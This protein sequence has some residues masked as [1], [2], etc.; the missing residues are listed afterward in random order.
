MQ[1][2]PKQFI[3][4]SRLLR[5]SETPWESKLWMHLRDRRFLGSRFKR[6]VRL[7]NYVVDFYCA[8]KR[9][10][11][12]LDGGQHNVDEIGKKDKQKENYLKNVEA[13]TVLR[14]WN[15]ELDNNLEGVLETIRRAVMRPHP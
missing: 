7:G 11:I 2:V 14:F 5:R 4:I 9:L 6:Q 8:E 3:K 1:I 13:L 12:E 15:N 10:V